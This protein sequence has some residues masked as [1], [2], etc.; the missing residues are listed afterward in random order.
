MSIPRT[1]LKGLLLLTRAITAIMP[2]R[3]PSRVSLFGDSQCTIF[4]VECKQRTHE[5]WFGNQVTHIREH[6]HSW[7]TLGIVVD[8]LHH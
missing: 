7:H 6:M 4:V 5:V 3:L 8:D 2:N 1:E